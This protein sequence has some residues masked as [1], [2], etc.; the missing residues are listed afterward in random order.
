DPPAAVVRD[1]QAAR[2]TGHQRRADVPEQRAG[3]EEP[4]REPDPRCDPGGLRRTERVMNG[5]R[6][7]LR[8]RRRPASS[9]RRHR[10]GGSPDADRGDGDDEDEQATRGQAAEEL[11]VGSFSWF[12]AF[13]GF[14]A[15]VVPPKLERSLRAGT[16]I[17]N[18]EPTAYAR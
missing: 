6:E 14:S 16:S 3:R 4:V 8:R 5:L 2:R 1:P 18:R 10:N 15:S 13:S 7:R 9:A 12:S 11:H 17:V